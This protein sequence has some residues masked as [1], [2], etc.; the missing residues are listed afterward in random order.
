MKINLGRTRGMVNWRE[1]S[2]EFALLAFL[3]L[4]W[5]PAEDLLDQ[6]TEDVFI[7]H[8]FVTAGERDN[9]MRYLETDTTNTT[10]D[11][12]QQWLSLNRA[13]ETETQARSFCTVS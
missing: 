12:V 4:Q 2:P 6:E 8:G 10:Y 3:A 11:K 5:K 7:K 13:G 1:E 9:F